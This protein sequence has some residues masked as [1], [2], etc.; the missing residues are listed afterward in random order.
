MS[1][2]DDFIK[3]FLVESREG[4]DRLD[5]DLI[6][7]EENPH[8][9]DRCDS[10]FRSLH[11]IKGNAGFLDFHRLGQLA[12]AG[13]NVLQQLRGGQL[14]LNSA[15]TDAL[16]EL[17]DALRRMLGSIENTSSEGSDRFDTVEV[18]LNS[19]TESGD[20]PT[21]PPIID[22]SVFSATMTFTPE[23]GEDPAV[24]FSHIKPET[25]EAGTIARALPPGDRPSE[26]AVTTPASSATLAPV[27]ATTQES[28]P[29]A[30]S[31]TD[32]GS[33]FARGES[34]FASSDSASDH[35]SSHSG[36]AASSL[37]RVDVHLLD[38][39]MNLVGELVLAR[40]Q[41]VETFGDQRDKS[42]TNPV[43][44]LNLLTSEL[45]EGV[46]KT[47]M[48]QIGSI[49]HRYPRMVRDLARS[50]GK[51]VT[52]DVQGDQTELDKTLLEA[53]TDPLLHLIRNS[54]DHGIESPDER[55]KRGKPLNGRLTLRAWHQGGH[56]HIDVSDDGAGL[57]ADRIRQ[58][59]IQRGLITAAQATTMTVDELH[60]LLFVAGF[61][62]SDAITSLS[63]RGVGLDVVR[64]NIEHIGGTVDVESVTGKG[65]TIHITVPL[66]LAIIPALI[67]RQSGQRYAIPQINVIE[68]I[69]LEG[70]EA[71]QPGE[72]YHNAPVIRLRGELLPLLWLSEVF[73]GG[74]QPIAED[75][76]DGLSLVVVQAGARR[77]ALVVDSVNGTEEIVVKPLGSVLDSLMFYTGATIMG[78]GTV[79]LILDILGVARHAG[80]QV[81]M[82]SDVDV[83]PAMLAQPRDTL[84][85][86]LVCLVGR[87]RIG[88]PLAEVTR[89]TS[90]ARDGIEIAGQ[91]EMLQEDDSLLPL[92]R[93]H[94]LLGEP[95]S[96]SE[97]DP[98]P[99]VVHRGRHGT[100][101]LIVDRILDIVEQPDD[102]S[103]HVLQ[104]D[105]RAVVLNGKVTDLIDLQTLIGRAG[106]ESDAV[107]ESVPSR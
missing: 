55:Q 89:L 102:T 93:A 82:L 96:L 52:L 44:R 50:C 34:L 56:V 24:E 40:N 5:S 42:T 4:L 61:S 38:R 76:E 60:P 104:D 57:N 28:Q 30:P 65:T 3:E 19:L 87:R 106:M 15:I 51:Q 83:S 10:A 94:Q 12:H 68:L 98:L 67:I 77:F 35:G 105:V 41:I 27:A 74:I 64:T 78:D 18:K 20:V 39:L 13:E 107:I 53:L 37:V 21:A 73:G 84:K 66:T 33:S 70:P 7:L 72:L 86:L 62:T 63:G 45:Q 54:I 80:L 58:K 59:A 46:L 26:A 100:I 99:V 95:A 97:S 79:A 9:L 36:S 2:S 91:R 1:Q 43:Q 81:R 48:Q 101:G 25:F 8:D 17:L 16:L 88:L 6:A 85:N 49:W 22:P 47:R 31:L 75:S 32:I 14:Q 90:V 69:N 103:M 11:T 92:F 71:N 29:E 23:K